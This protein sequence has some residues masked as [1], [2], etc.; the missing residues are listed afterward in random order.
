MKPAS[1]W[2]NQPQRYRLEAARCA[3]CDRVAFPPR[4]I[5]AGCGG[6]DFQ[7]HQLPMTGH[8]V[9]F[10]IQHVAGAQ[11]ADDTPFAVGIIEMDDG[12][13]LTAQIADIPLQDLAIGRRIRLAFRKLQEAGEA[14]VIAYAHKAVPEEPAVPQA[15][16]D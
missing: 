13:R 14:G 11:F 12:T 9:T 8:I 16:A 7:N 6:R 3:A 2:R 4:P 5:C 10:T 15:P 1:I